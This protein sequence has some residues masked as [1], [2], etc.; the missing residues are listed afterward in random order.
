[1]R[2]YQS[3]TSSSRMEYIRSLKLKY[4]R[5][6]MGLTSI[7]ERQPLVEHSHNNRMADI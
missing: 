1:M 5:H 4:S 2:N 7:T 6:Q 3:L